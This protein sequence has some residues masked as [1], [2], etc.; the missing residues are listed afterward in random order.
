M[1]VRSLAMYDEFIADFSRDAGTSIEY[2]RCGTLEVAADAA[3]PCASGAGEWL[4]SMASIAR[5]PA[6]G[7]TR[8]EPA[9][10]GTEGA[11]LVPSHGYVRA[12]QLTAALLA[13]A[14]RSGAVVHSERRVENIA[15]EG[16]DV[17][18]TAGDTSYR[19]GTL[20]IAAGSWSGPLG[21]TAVKPV[22]GQ[23][24]QLRWTGPAI[25]RVLWSDG[26]YIVPWVDGT[27]LVG[28]T[29][30]DVGFDER[31]TAGGVQA[32]LSAASALLPGVRGATFVEARVGL[33]PATPSGLPIIA[34][35]AEHPSIVFA[36]GHYRNGI[37]LAPLTPSSS[38]ISYLYGGGIH[39]H[40]ASPKTNKGRKKEG[41]NSFKRLNSLS[42]FLLFD[43]VGMLRDCETSFERGK[44]R[45][46]FLAAAYF[47]RGLERDDGELV[48]QA[49][50]QLVFLATR[51]R[52]GPG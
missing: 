8:L 6:V 1:A 28:A 51:G 4:R 37:L 48:V 42:R 35:S 49:G 26:C 13:A 44:L 17:M 36:T 31:V 34:R 14:R 21:A 18:V 10:G 40:A 33:R 39:C 25:T 7:V 27:L 45:P 9:M 46:P 22:R 38:R 24:L 19:A 41:S 43:L 47:R 3:A 11:L 5:V 52:A 2:R 50:L 32:L 20:V 12:A 30:E 16:D 23:L 29:V 15:F